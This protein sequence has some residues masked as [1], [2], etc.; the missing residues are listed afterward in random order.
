MLLSEELS[1][2]ITC[3]F[4][5]VKKTMYFCL[6]CFHHLFVVVFLV[7][8]EALH[9]SD[10]GACVFVCLYLVCRACVEQ[11]SGILLSTSRYVCTCSN[12]CIH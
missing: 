2:I 12:I 10:R 8:Q 9:H 4:D 6:F 7:M 1:H 5:A 3:N 11:A